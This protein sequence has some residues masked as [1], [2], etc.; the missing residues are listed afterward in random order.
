MEVRVGD[1]Q[2]QI[3]D[4]EQSFWLWSEEQTGK[5]QEWMTGDQ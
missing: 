1:P 3:R 4:L 5:Q 2:E